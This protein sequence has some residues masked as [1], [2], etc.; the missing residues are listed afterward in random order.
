M[1]VRTLSLALLAPAALLLSAHR[2]LAEPVEWAYAGQVLTNPNWSVD[3]RSLSPVFQKADKST[4]GNFWALSLE[5]RL[6]FEG[7]SGDASGSDDVAAFRIRSSASDPDGGGVFHADKHTFT[8]TF[9]LTDKASGE[10]GALTFKGALTSGGINYQ[11]AKAT[12]A[13]SSPTSQSVQLGGHV[14][15]VTVSPFAY[16]AKHAPPAPFIRVGPYQ[17]VQVSVAV[18]D[19]PEPTALA[20][21]ALGLP[22]LVALARRP[23]RARPAH[24][25]R[26]RAGEMAR[27]L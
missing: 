13:F 20:L 17:D 10:S 14:Y 1:A 7:L 18:S 9:G 23:V 8:L 15:T 24:P 3:S 6:E 12:G 2:A 26:R 25:R 27:A 16:D 11:E 19:V 5:Q 4:G 22:G 21:A